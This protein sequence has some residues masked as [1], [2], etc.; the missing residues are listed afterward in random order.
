MSRRL[1][2]RIQ[3]KLS[4]D[5]YFQQRRDATGKLGLSTLQ[6]CTAALRMLAYGSAADSLDEN[7]RM[8]ESTILETVERF[9]SDIFAIFGEEYLR[10]PNEDDYRRILSANQARGFPGMLGS[11]DCMHWRWKS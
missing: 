3:E 4:Q 1:F 6:K 8:A 2:D 9:T 7:I 5:T 10:S 11:L